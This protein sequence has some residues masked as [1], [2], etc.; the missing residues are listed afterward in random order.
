MGLQRNRRRA[1]GMAVV[2]FTFAAASACTDDPREREAAKFRCRVPLADGGCYSLPADCPVTIPHA[3][4]PSCPLDAELVLAA[5]DSC[6]TKRIC[7]D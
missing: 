2:M 7:T 3:D 4:V 5:E 1:A 6:A